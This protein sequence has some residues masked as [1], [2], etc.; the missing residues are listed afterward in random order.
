[1]NTSA[2]IRFF[3][4]TA[5][6]LPLFTPSAFAQPRAGQTALGAEVGIFVPKDE[7]LDIGGVAAGL[8]EVYATPRVGIRS[9]VTAIRADYARNDNDD[10][11]QLRFGVDVIRNWEFGRVHPF[12][13]AGIA[14][15]LLRFYRDGNN[16]GPNDTKFG[17]QGLGGAEFFLNRA[18]T[19]KAEGRYQWVADRP[20]L[21]PDGLSL[22]FGVK[23]YF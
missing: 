6:L 16:E 7:Q 18:W 15:H 20:N 13:G 8:F 10:E 19:V 22:T 21:D 23:R 11:R 14:M 5:L 17:A 3:S 9:T 1:M 4:L 2:L 12:A